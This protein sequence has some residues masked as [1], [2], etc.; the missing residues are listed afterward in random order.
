MSGGGGGRE[1]VRQ[2]GF[3]W[4]MRGSGGGDDD[5]SRKYPRKVRRCTSKKADRRTSSTW[6][7][8][9]TH[10]PSLHGS[11]F[12][13]LFIAANYGLLPP[14]ASLPPV[15]PPQTLGRNTRRRRTPPMLLMD[16]SLMKYLDES[17]RIYCAPA[18]PA[19][20]RIVH[21]KPALISPRRS[22]GL[23]PK[24]HPLPRSAV[25]PI[26]FS[27]RA[28]DVDSAR[29]FALAEE[30]GGVLADKNDHLPA[31]GQ[32]CVIIMFFDEKKEREEKRVI[33]IEEF[34]FAITFDRYV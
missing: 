4:L 9:H 29:V 18:R 10:A 12:I 24:N 31:N 8:T 22:T 1:A 16:S 25:I 32:C 28:R 5:E 33:D 7:F 15:S 6:K 11:C 14:C 3:S 26:P 2:S 23:S 13:A 30:R 34:T 17:A 27:A 21:D 19:L 20:S